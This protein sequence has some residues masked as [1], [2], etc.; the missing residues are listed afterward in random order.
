ME[1]VSNREF[2]IEQY[3]LSRWEVNSYII[4]CP[5][6]GQSALIDAPPASATL[7]K[8]LEETDLRYILLTHGHI[9]HIAGL[10][11]F[12]SR[13]KVP[14][15]VHPDDQNLLESPP[16]LYLKDGDVIQIGKIDISV[17]HTPG[18]T[19][20]SVCFRLG[21]YLI[22]GDT[23]FP[24]GPGR[25][26]TPEDFQQELKSIREKVLV[27]PEE[28]VVYPGHGNHTTLK[29]AKEEYAVFASRPHKPGL[30]GDVTWLG[31]E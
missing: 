7:L 12:Q 3:Q 27:L 5:Q 16:D 20:G 26:E 19:P 2:R 24:G 22:S 10:P 1:I 9:D 30:C 4:I 6:T 29:A 15:A 11:A 14:L 23:I 25:T 8:R 13:R 21:P 18:H 28:T 17:M 31:E